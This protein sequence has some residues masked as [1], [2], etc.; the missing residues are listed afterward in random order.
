MNLVHILIILVTFVW[1]G[2]VG[3]ISFMEAWLKFRAPGVTL[4]IGLSIGRK[5][6]TAL[7]RMVIVF[8]GVIF[9]LLSQKSFLTVGEWLIAVPL[10]MLVLQS[11]LLLPIL[12]SRTDAILRYENVGPSRVHFYFIAAELLKVIFLF[13]FGVSVISGAVCA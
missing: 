9:I 11:L 13:A 8:A 1:A 5:V 7:N 3:A 4:R 12:N 6:F 2:F 10:A